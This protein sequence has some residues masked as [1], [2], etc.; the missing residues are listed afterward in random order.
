MT[1]AG[2]TLARGVPF[3]K[4]VPDNAV[5]VVAR[6]LG[7]APSTAAQ[8]LRFS[9]PR[10]PFGRARDLLAALIT[11]GHPL[12]AEQIYEEIGLVLQGPVIAG[13]DELDVLEQE[14]DGR[15]NE[16]QLLR[17]IERHATGDARRRAW[18]TERRIRIQYQAVNRRLIRA[19]DAAFGRP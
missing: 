5:R 18:G 14:L 13:F 3:A 17:C 15:E 16:A 8:V 7:C 11:G 1:A 2:P 4:Y 10:S 12:R 19:G 9:D 6:A